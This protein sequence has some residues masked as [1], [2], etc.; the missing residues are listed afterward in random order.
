MSEYFI[1]TKGEE[2]GPYAESQLRSMWNSGIITSDTVFRE[3]ESQ[4]WRPISRLLE[5]EEVV[6]TADRQQPT[7]PQ[8]DTPQPAPVSSPAPPKK[9]QAGAIA[10]LVILL[11]IIAGMILGNIHVISGARL[12]SPRIVK[13]ESF[14]FSETFINIDTITHMPWISA[15]SRYPLSCA[16]LMRERLIESEEEFRERRDKQMKEDMQKALQNLNR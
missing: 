7:T 2:K 4:D 16:V 9:S 12:E 6:V 8:P 11:A 14:G 15:Q 1:K 10:A 5:P 3:S 13:R